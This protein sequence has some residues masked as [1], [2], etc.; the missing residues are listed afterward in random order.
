MANLIKPTMPEKN[1]K[2]QIEKLYEEIFT[3]AKQV[4]PETND[5]NSQLTLPPLLPLNLSESAAPL[6]LNFNDTSKN[7]INKGIK[8]QDKIQGLSMSKIIQDE[9]LMELSE[10]ESVNN[11]NI[12]KRDFSSE[13]STLEESQPVTKIKKKG[14]GEYGSLEKGD[15]PLKVVGIRPVK[16]ENDLEIMVSWMPREN[17]VKPY[18]SKVMR[19]ELLKRGF[20]MPLIEFYESKMKLEGAPH[21]DPQLLPKH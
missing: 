21:F 3:K 11:Q 20:Y 5:L 16:E 14:K 10:N 4:C 13:V 17:G 9:K 15:K 6:A 12:D 7:I 2:E 1:S 18:N 19:V 8:D